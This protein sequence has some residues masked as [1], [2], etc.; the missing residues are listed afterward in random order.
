MIFISGYSMDMLLNK[1]LLVE[2]VD[3][4]TKPLH[5]VELAR[6]VRELLDRK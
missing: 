1:G 2:G 4:L 6:K 3:L 5:S